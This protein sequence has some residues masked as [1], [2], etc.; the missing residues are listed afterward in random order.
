MHRF[1]RCKRERL[2][3]IT[4]S[5]TDHGFALFRILLD[6]SADSVSNLGEQVTGF[7]FE[8]MFVNEGHR[9]DVRASIL[10]KPLRI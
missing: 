8:I 1:G 2:G 6:E 7:K 9:M 3:D 5:T 10:L 4:N